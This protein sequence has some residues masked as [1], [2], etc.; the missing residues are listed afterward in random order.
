MAAARDCLYS[1]A[2]V[3]VKSGNPASA[4]LS[5][6]WDCQT[7]ALLLSGSPDVLFIIFGQFSVSRKHGRRQLACVWREL[8]RHLLSAE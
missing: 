4:A 1:I 3:A 7:W 5:V 6:E 2:D 8:H